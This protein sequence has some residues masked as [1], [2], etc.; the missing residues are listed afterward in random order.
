M[1][2][3][4]NPT[5]YIDLFG[6]KAVSDLEKY[7]DDPAYGR[8]DNDPNNYDNYSA[9][10]GA[11]Y[12]EFSQ[13]IAGDA[14]ISNGHAFRKSIR[15]VLGQFGFTKENAKLSALVYVEDDQGEADAKKEALEHLGKGFRQQYGSNE[16]LRDSFDAR[17]KGVQ[18]GDLVNISDFWAKS[19][20]DTIDRAD[21]TS[22][23]IFKGVPVL[24]QVNSNAI[25]KND[26]LAPP[27]FRKDAAVSTYTDLALTLGPIALKGLYGG[28][29]LMR[30]VRNSASRNR[31]PWKY[32]ET[33][34]ALGTT[35]KYGN[36]RIKPGL[37]GEELVET[38]RHEGVHRF[39]SPKAEFMKEPR[40]DLGMSAY[41]N[42]HLLRYLE[43]AA[44]ETFATKS[45]RKGLLFPVEY[46]Y[47]SPAQTLIEGAA[48]LGGTGAGAYYGYKWSVG[49]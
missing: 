43:E 42:S 29:S 24:D 23:R 41:Q 27:S 12:T 47:V 38:V 46:G 1:Y 13:E 30:G 6:Y 48:Y 7:F 31:I 45:I 11:Y 8:G 21:G 17:F 26:T 2:A 28:R 32:G 36:I 19:V 16:A 9:D 37:K 44:A 25:V 22:G 10:Y 35:D 3:Y 39:L 40:A 20:F 18:S 4:S 15:P 49:E 34:G 33:D 14:G 5:V